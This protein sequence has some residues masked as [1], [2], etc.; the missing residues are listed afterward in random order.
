MNYVEKLDQIQKLVINF[1]RNSS[2]AIKSAVD[3]YK[4]SMSLVA[5][6]NKCNLLGKREENLEEKWESL[7]NFCNFVNS[8]GKK[9]FSVSALSS[10]IL[11]N[12]EFFGNT[13]K[14]KIDGKKNYLVNRYEFIKKMLKISACR[15]L[16]K[17]ELKRILDE[18]TK[19]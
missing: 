11:R 8:K 6:I 2:E 7:E 1:E 15:D 16:E 14:K 3:L 4:Q 18:H 17:I 13:C 10:R 5:E 9:I 12:V 19:K